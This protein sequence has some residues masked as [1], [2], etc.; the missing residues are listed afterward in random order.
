MWMCEWLSCKMWI[1]V[2]GWLLC[3]VRRDRR[4]SRRLGVSLTSRLLSKIRRA[5]FQDSIGDDKVG[6]EG[7]E[8]RVDKGM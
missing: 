4:M 1:G 2:V 8:V 7:Y 5:I 3:D 6:M